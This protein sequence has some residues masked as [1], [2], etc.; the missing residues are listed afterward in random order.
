[1]GGVARKMV[2]D[3]VLRFWYKNGGGTIYKITGLYLATQ[4]GN[5]PFCDDEFCNR[6]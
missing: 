3:M 5:E 6:E 1:M 2:L 4:Q